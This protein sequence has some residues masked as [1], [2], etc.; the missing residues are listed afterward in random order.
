MR[1]GNKRVKIPRGHPKLA[2]ERRSKGKRNK[3][4]KRNSGRN[5][6]LIKN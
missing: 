1:K 6:G 5:D 3:S 2:L 4:R